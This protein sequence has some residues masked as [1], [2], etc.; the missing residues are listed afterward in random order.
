MKKQLVFPFHSALVQ[1]FV[2]KTRK[3]SLNLTNNVIYVELS[4]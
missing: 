4:H 2:D 1:T 3:L